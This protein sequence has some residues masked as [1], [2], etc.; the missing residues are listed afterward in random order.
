MSRRMERKRLGKETEGRKEF[1]VWHEMNSKERG[2]KMPE[3]KGKSTHL[4][5]STSGASRRDPPLS[6]L[7]VV[8][9]SPPE[10]LGRDQLQRRRR[11][12]DLLWKGVW[13]HSYNEATEKYVE[14]FRGSFGECST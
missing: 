9:V 2:R 12:R 11:T 14:C 13:S 10:L 8:A 5:A 6:L 7:E 3:T 4:T 1:A